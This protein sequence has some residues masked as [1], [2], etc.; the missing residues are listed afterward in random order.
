MSI[1]IGASD[2]DTREKGGNREF[3]RTNANSRS[4]RNAAPE[5]VEFVT[6]SVHIHLR[7]GHG[8]AVRDASGKCHLMPM[9][10]ADDQKSDPLPLHDQAAVIHT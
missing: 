1:R 10:T 4:S 7:G 5:Q 8:L 6:F 2:E 9:P 3:R